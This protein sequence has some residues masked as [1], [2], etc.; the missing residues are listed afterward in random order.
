MPTDED[1]VTNG[2]IFIG[3]EELDKTLTVHTSLYDDVRL[4]VMVYEPR[5]VSESAGGAD[6]VYRLE[7]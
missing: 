5:D 7:Q 3:L 6:S 2:Y 4:T 1:L